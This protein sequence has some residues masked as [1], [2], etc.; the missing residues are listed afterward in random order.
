MTKLYTTENGKAK[1]IDLPDNW[2]SMPEAFEHKEDGSI[3]FAP[4]KTRLNIPYEMK[5]RNFV[6]INV[7]MFQRGFTCIYLDGKDLYIGHSIN[8]KRTKIEHEHLDEWIKYF[9]RI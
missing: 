4:K 3:T 5:R 1:V 2:Q 9:D 6:R 7:E 8:D